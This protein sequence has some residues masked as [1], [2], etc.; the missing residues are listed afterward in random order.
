MLHKR[1]DLV[2]VMKTLCLKPEKIVRSDKLL[3][4]VEQI[5]CHNYM[6]SLNNVPA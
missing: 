1:A 4:C 3:L 6:E 5:T 2:G